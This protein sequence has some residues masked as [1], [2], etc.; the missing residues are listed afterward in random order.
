MNI[1]PSQ[2]SRYLSVDI[3]RGLAI[4]IMIEAHLAV[5]G[6][7]GVLNDYA[8]I[9]AGPF[10]LIAAGLSYELFILSRTKK[11]IAITDIFLEST[12]R[13]FTL[14][15]LTVFPI[16][17]LSITRIINISPIHWTIFIVISLGYIIG[18]ITHR[19]TT[20]KIIS[21]IIVFVCTFMIKLYQTPLSFLAEGQFPVL[22]F[23]AYFILGQVIVMLYN[24][25][26]VS[27]YKKVALI[28]TLTICILSGIVLLV[29]LNIQFDQSNRNTIPMF[30]II[31]G[32]QTF[33]ILLLRDSV[34]KN[35]LFSR[36]L[37]P[38]GNL[39][40]ISFSAYYIHLGI[41]YA[42]SNIFLRVNLV[43]PPISTLLF[44]IAIT[45]CIIVIERVWRNYDYIFGFEWLL[46]K[47]SKIMM[48]I[49]Y[50]MANRWQ[51]AADI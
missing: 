23:I 28:I 25:W 39:G 48:N 36:L 43:I 30:L 42:L 10:F 3:V 33:I 15:I 16:F 24:G 8:T 51:K 50:G 7:L 2:K 27:K 4:L 37:K 9:F 41:I 17:I 31:S 22:P 11:K 40:L 20:L 6:T 45:I 29:Y 47:I 34:D 12:F 13:A 19:S 32:I 49:F 14:I 44:L 38:I 26:D 46:R 35:N 5:L 1:D 18:Y 21:I